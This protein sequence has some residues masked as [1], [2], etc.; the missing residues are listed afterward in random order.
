M[1]GA[2]GCGSRGSR[3]YGSQ[4]RTIHVL[5]AAVVNR[6]LIALQCIST[7]RCAHGALQAGARAAAD[8]RG[9]LPSR[10]SSLRSLLRCPRAPASPRAGSPPISSRRRF[11]GTRWRW[12]APLPLQAAARLV[13]HHCT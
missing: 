11:D 10:L 2:G 13:L 3:R 7:S 5:L 6:T 8:H 1:P 4:Q 12:A 9:R